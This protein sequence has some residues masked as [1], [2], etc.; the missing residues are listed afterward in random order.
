MLT[1]LLALLPRVS[2]AVAALPEFVAVIRKAKAAMSEK[3]QKTLQ[4]AYDL[5]R[6]GSDEA[7]AEL[8]ALVAA[9]RG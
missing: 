7:N 2:S 4:T 3:D 8:E 9:H 1:E 5:A 6:A